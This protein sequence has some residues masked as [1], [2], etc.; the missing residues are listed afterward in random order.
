MRFRRTYV[1]IKKID[2]LLPMFVFK[3]KGIYVLRNKIFL[4]NWGFASDIIIEMFY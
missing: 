2:K 4:E 1:L 3:D